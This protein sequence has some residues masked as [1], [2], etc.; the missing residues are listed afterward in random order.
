MGHQVTRWALWHGD[1]TPPR[2]LGRSC[3][4]AVR[5]GY[6][7][8]RALDTPASRYSHRLPWAPTPP[9]EANLPAHWC[10]G[11][12]VQPS[13]EALVQPPAP[14]V[15]TGDSLCLSESLF[16]CLQNGS[17]N[18]F[19]TSGDSTEEI[20]SR[21]QGNDQGTARQGHF[22]TRLTER[23]SISA[24]CPEPPRAPE[25]PA[26]C[27]LLTFSSRPPSVIPVSEQTRAGAQG[28]PGYADR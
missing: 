16:P 9:T 20:K 5:C 17:N 25:T 4:P 15:T 23:E 11:L 10:V 8:G 18:I 3:H 21:C 7:H 24:T 1:V 2:S 22:S 27:C 28:A 14:L 13:R 12:R 6:Q 26:C 19:A